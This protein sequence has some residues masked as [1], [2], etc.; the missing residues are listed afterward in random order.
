MSSEIR[1]E[2]T[3]PEN[4]SPPEFAP[5]KS[6]NGNKVSGTSKNAG[7]ILI[8]ELTPDLS[9]QSRGKRN[10]QVILIPLLAIITG[11]IIGAI[12]IILTSEEFYTALQ[13]S[14]LDG[15]KTAVSIVA[16]TY[17]AWL[18]GAIGD[19]ADLVAFF[20]TGDIEGFT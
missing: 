15:L 14:I 9:T 2:N 3:P 19:P 1:N 18:K 20:Q 16:T 7:Q 5:E 6:V 4:S 13:V 17:G 11:L 8:E 12:F 10:L